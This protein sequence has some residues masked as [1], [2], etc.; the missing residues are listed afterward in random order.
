MSES[1]DRIEFAAVRREVT[2]RGA[3]ALFAQRLNRDVR[4]WK[5]HL[6]V[7]GAI[8]FLFTRSSMSATRF[9]SWSSVNAP[10]LEYLR[11]W[12][13]MGFFLILAGGVVY[14]SQL[15]TEEK[16]QGT[17]AL[18]KLTGVGSWAILS[19]LFASRLAQMLIVLTL[20]LP[21]I[22]WSVTLG[23]VTF[24]QVLALYL[25]LLS[26]LFLVG[27]LALWTSV[28]ART[29]K[30]TY[31]SCIVIL[32]APSLMQSVINGILVASQAQSQTSMLSRWLTVVTQFLNAASP[33]QRIEAIQMTGYS[34]PLLNTQVW[35][36]LALG[37]GF[38]IMSGL[39]FERFAIQAEPVN[40]TAD[41]SIIPS[42]PFSSRRR[43]QRCWNNPYLW[44]EFQHRK[45]GIRGLIVSSLLAVG[46][47]AFLIFALPPIL[48]S[49]G[50]DEV[51]ISDSLESI[52]HTWLWTAIIA[53]CILPPLTVA[54]T[55]SADLKQQTLG[56][57]FLVPRQPSRILMSLML[58]RWLL[59]S[60]LLV[61][62]I[63]GFAGC[64]MLLSQNFFGGST[65]PEIPHWRPWGIPFIAAASFVTTLTLGVLGIRFSLIQSGVNRFLLLVLGF[66]LFCPLMA[67]L[68]SPIIVGSSLLHSLR[69]EDVIGTLMGLFVYAAFSIPVVAICWDGILFSIRERMEND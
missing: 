27:N 25:T 60:H 14:F 58:G 68:F 56:T 55:L 15:I 18:L 65:L 23:G 38:F 44:K 28:I 2:W 53:G 43:S 5:F 22:L 8:F 33:L 24:H 49:A 46:I 39:L 29:G 64:M 12:S 47:N 13:G 34:D 42:L 20:Q 41:R 31:I 35:T 62:L 30:T 67:M 51:R 1:L 26:T 36:S 37:L 59:M 66:F 17:L 16:Q 61:W 4:D 7:A 32:L 52:E 21:F 9:G 57:L 48:L 40:L 6:L 10:G 54:Q 69:D 63:S 50:F 45:L 11:S 3:F 19:G